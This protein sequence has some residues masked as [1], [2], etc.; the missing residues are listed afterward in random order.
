[1]STITET[2]TEKLLDAIQ[3]PVELQAVL[4]EYSHNKGPLYGA[5]AQATST[6]TKKLTTVG[7]QYGELGAK[8]KEREQHL[9][10]TEQKQSVLDQQADIKSKTLFALEQKV[11]INISLLNQVKNLDELGFGPGELEK[12]HHV[13]TTNVPT[14][15][16]SQQAIT[17]FFKFVDKYPHLAEVDSE[18]QKK[19]IEVVLLDGKLNSKQALIAEVKE[20]SE[21]G[22]GAKDL[23]KL[24]HLLVKFG[25]S[26]GM[27]APEIL[28]LFF[29]YVNKF[30]DAVSLDT[31]I[32]QLQTTA[33]TAKADTEQWQAWAKAAEA[34]TKARK[35]SIEITEK[36]IVHGVKERDLPKWQ[37][38]L[39]KCGV[40]VDVLSQELA[41]FASLE[42]LCQN[43]QQQGDK[44]ETRVITLTAQ[45]K[46]LSGELNQVSA[47]ITAVR[48]KALAE[49]EL[50]NLTIIE[51]LQRLAS[52]TENYKKLQQEAAPLRDY[53]ALAKAIKMHD[54]ELWGQVSQETARGL[55]SNLLL[56]CKADTS[57]NP[58]M[59]PPTGSL[60]GKA[61]FF[62]W[63]KVSLE[64]VLRWALTGL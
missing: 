1:M 55:M 6:L 46:A 27:A 43:R 30:Q 2:I 47:S 50:T 54:P 18:V 14:G 33:A 21:L 36:L 16:S 53:L 22:L 11:Q 9:K 12:L 42:K 17:L 20:V 35:S 31:Q 59:E 41:Q 40:S 26:Q 60:A 19:E 62:T 25:A 23:G 4:E 45:V 29:D 58:D 5:L 63:Y 61:T 13:L 49:V 34:K 48:D 24:H 8:L 7:Q 3:D 44:L 15:G 38:I 56:W 64:E 51:N 28:K 39:E 37:N 57:H 10:E 32:Q 52:E